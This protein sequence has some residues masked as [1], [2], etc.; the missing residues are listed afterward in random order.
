LVA[1]YQ[2]E[3]EASPNPTPENQADQD[4]QHAGTGRKQA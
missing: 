3:A 1:P 4:R 2:N